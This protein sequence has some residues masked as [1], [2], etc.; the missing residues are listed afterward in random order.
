MI[1]TERADRPQLILSTYVVEYRRGHYLLGVD[2]YS[3]WPEFAELENLSCTNTLTHLKSLFSKY[4]IPDTLISDNVPNVQV[5]NSSTSQEA[6]DLFKRS[7][8]L[9][10]HKVIDKQYTPY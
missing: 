4:G 3:K 7:A 6:M 10:L 5:R 8:A 2:H 9:T 1:I